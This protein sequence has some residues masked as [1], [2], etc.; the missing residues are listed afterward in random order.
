MLVHSENNHAPSIFSPPPREVAG[1]NTSQRFN[2]QFHHLGYHLVPVRWV[3]PDEVAY[4]TQIQ[5]T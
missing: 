3:V 1:F 2:Q 5:Y 4:S